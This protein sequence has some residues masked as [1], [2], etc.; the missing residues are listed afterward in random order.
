MAGAL[1]RRG[2]AVGFALLT[3]VLFLV[4]HVR[5]SN[6]D[7]RNPTRQLLPLTDLQ[8]AGFC[9]PPNALGYCPGDAGVVVC[10]SGALPD[11]G[12][13]WT[14]DSSAGATGA[15][16]AIGPTGAAGATGTAGNAGATGATG[17]TG[18]VTSGSAAGW[19]QGSSVAA[20]GN[21]TAFT[22]AGFT[23]VA[24]TFKVRD[25]TAQWTTIGTLGTVGAVI[26]VYDKTASSSFCHCTLGACT[27]AINTQLTC[28]CNSGTST[29]AHNYVFRWY[30]T[31]DCSLNPAGVT[32][33]A[34]ITT[35]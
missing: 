24:N 23:S 26:E 22:S 16:G 3:P 20:L 21:S 32:L 33:N 4:A 34:E 17:A 15:T 5:P 31:D 9:S 12:Y 30:S 28:D 18:T 10:Q 1:V 29:A 7:V 11:G 25:I 14:S 8:C 35:P 27:T 13:G 6:A 2:I 19:V